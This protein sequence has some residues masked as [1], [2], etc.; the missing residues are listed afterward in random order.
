MSK[1]K[2]Q[3]FED[4]RYTVDHD[5]YMWIVIWGP[6]RASKTTLAGHILY[7]LYKDWNI[8]LNAFVTSLPELIHKIKRGIPET[9]PTVTEPTHMRVP[10]LNYDDWGAK[11][12]KASTQYSEAWDEF[13]GGFDVIGRRIG[14]LV[15]TMVDPTEPTFQI[16]NKY[17]HEIR[18][19]RRGLYKYDS[20]EW[21]QDYRGW[22]PRARKRCQEI[23][24]FDPWPLEIYKQYDAEIR[25]DLTDEVFMRIEDKLAETHVEHILKR[26]KPM[27]FQVLQLIVDRGVLRKDNEAYN[28]IEKDTIIRLKSRNLITPIK[29]TASRYGYD[30]TNLGIEVLDAKKNAETDKNAITTI[31]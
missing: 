5:A 30:I 7:S 24:T 10:A 8:V 26:A 23:N 17:T 18:I 9:W 14:V 29:V 12:N 3:L 13:K 6:A 21:E 31:N 16:A 25:E 19:L 22:R 11:S 15:G 20:V 2:C 27:D 1:E 4:V 28:K